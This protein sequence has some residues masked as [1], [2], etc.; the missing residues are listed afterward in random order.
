MSV[1]W[2]EDAGE[3]AVLAKV[4]AGLRRG[5]R[6]RYVLAMHA[7]KLRPPSFAD[8]PAWQ[9]ALRAPVQAETEEEREAVAKAMRSG[10]LIPGA[11]VSSE[12]ERRRRD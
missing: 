5:Q 4:F 9:S 3:D 6:A 8:H 2:G 11:D 10:E 12:L 7:K 1:P